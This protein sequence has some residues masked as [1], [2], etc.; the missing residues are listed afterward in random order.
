MSGQFTNI[1]VFVLYL[2]GIFII[3][4]TAGR[5]NKDNTDY[6]IGGR[7]M[8]KW[9]L[10]ASTVASD[11]SGF[12]FTGIAGMF[13]LTGMPV[14]ADYVFILIIYIVIFFTNALRLRK[15]AQVLNAIT[16]PDYFEARFQDEKKHILRYA[17]VFI[18]IVGVTVYIMSQFMA[19][20]KAISSLF[21]WSRTS[22]IL[23]TAIFVVFYTTAGGFFAVCWTDFFQAIL[24][25]GAS[26]VLGF[27][28]L[29]LVG[30]FGPGL[31]TL[32]GM[33]A[34]GTLDAS[35]TN[36]FANIP[37]LVGFAFLTL[38]T[39]GYPH[40]NVRFMAAKNSKT[41]ISMIPIVIIILTVFQ[42]GT[43]LAGIFGRAIYPDASMLLNGDP[44]TLY[45][46][47]I[48]QHLP[49]VVSGLF[50]AGIVAAVMSTADSLL[51]VASS[52]VA[53]D[54]IYKVFKPDMDEKS[55][56]RLSQITTLVIGV[57]ATILAFFPF[58]SVFWV[59]S[60]AWNWFGALGPAIILSL[61]WK[62]VT[63]TGVLAGFFTGIVVGTSW[64]YIISLRDA[65]HPTGIAVISCAIV[66]Y[67]VSLMTPAPP[68]EQQ[69]MV[70]KFKP[71]Y[72]SSKPQK[73]LNAS[74]NISNFLGSK[75]TTA[76]VL[77]PN[78]N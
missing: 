63:K 53:N 48:L 17:I 60:Q 42:G 5:K 9:V 19:G 55:V 67:V 62:R 40:V 22:S 73:S 52:A 7:G 6:F 57:I 56:L 50:I 66:I 47:L 64:S 29:D 37:L 31:A 65:F 12:I 45:I 74:N 39:F 34:A 27:L 77:E 36:M 30:G 2:A 11:M 58:N 70:E 14:L 16:L 72:K 10:A 69:E 68:L 28:A 25:F 18:F 61:F 1:I 71:H 49:G 26:L 15:A 75:E 44:E 21:G 23:L 3:G 4:I 46:T 8:G 20:G 54:L 33:V 43:A 76:T 13:Y 38:G 59:A 32:N 35:F 51:L 41:V 78:M 24:M